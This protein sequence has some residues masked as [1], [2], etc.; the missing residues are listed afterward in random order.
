LPTTVILR[1]VEPFV[2][3]LMSAMRL[4]PAT[5]PSVLHNSSPV[6]VSLA[7]KYS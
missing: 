3:G 2:P 5:V 4:V 1:G 6:A 7:P